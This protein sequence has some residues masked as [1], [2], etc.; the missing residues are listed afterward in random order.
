MSRL[1][2][3]ISP[4]SKISSSSLILSPGSLTPLSMPGIYWINIH[5][6]NKWINT[7][8]LQHY[9]VLTASKLLY[10]LFFT[11]I[12]QFVYISPRSLRICVILKCR[13]LKANS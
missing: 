5:W 6:L 1:S 13:V 4:L 7:F 3:F 2:Y 11:M 10:S 9:Y 12:Q 8:I